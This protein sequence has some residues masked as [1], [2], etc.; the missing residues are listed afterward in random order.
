MAG[1]PLPTCEPE[2]FLAHFDA[3]VR[4]EGEATMVELLDA[5]GSGADI[6]AVP[7]V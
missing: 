1:G 2:A 5:H 6:G 7:G 3:V 4:G